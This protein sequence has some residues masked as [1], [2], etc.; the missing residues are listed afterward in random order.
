MKVKRFKLN[1]L[2]SESLHQKE[3]SAIIGGKDCSCSC[4]YADQGGAS[5]D[6]NNMANYN[7]GYHSSSGCNQYSY[8]DEMGYNYWPEAVHA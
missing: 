4:Y 3:M 7:Y 8:S 5:V 2:S 6:A 1:A